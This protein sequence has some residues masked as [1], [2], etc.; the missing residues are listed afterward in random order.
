MYNTSSIQYS[1]QNL[2]DAKL[3]AA[4]LNEWEGEVQFSIIGI[5]EKVA[6]LEEVMNV[7]IRIFG[8][9]IGIFQ[10]SSRTLSFPTLKYN[11]LSFRG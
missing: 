8:S 1:T 6:E 4:P 10:I 7:S 5:K 2:G 11:V 3:F 9:F